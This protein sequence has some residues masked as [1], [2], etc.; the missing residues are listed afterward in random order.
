MQLVSRLVNKRNVMKACLYVVNLSGP[1]ARSAGQQ[2][3]NSSFHPIAALV[4]G[5]P[6]MQDFA[7]LRTDNALLIKEPLVLYIVAHAVPNGLI[8]ANGETIQE[9]EVAKLIQQKRGDLPTVIVWDVCFAG[10]FLDIPGCADWSSNYV[11]IFACQDFER[12][13]QKK[14][15]TQ[16][17]EALKAALDALPSEKD[18]ERLDAELQK[19]LGTLQTPDIIA[20]ADAGMPADFF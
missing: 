6:S 3:R 12:T 20:G 16:F 10:S 5:A 19:Q 17:S 7:K 8:D 4:N 2:P 1:L 18:W 15:V 13:W 14:G 9:I 11:H